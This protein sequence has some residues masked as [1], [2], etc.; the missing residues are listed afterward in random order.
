MTLRKRIVVFLAT[1]LVAQ[2]V[3][4]DRASVS[5]CRADGRFFAFGGN[6]TLGVDDD[7]FQP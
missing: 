7:R 2:V 1:V 4:A 3:F 5:A 6:D